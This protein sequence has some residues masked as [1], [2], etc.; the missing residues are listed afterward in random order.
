MR[1]MRAALAAGCVLTASIP[2]RAQ[3][4]GDWTTVGND[5]QRS[6]W[7]RGDG[8]IS[9]QAIAKPGFQLAW[10]VKLKGEPRQMQSVTPPAL[11]DF[12]IGHRGFRALGFFGNGSGA[13]TG[14]DTDLSRIEWERNIA[15]GTRN[16]TIPCPGGVT[17]PLSR[18]TSLGYPGSF[19]GRGGRGTP[20]K[21][22]VGEAFEGAVTIRAQTPPPAPPPPPPSARR[23]A[24]APNP[25]ARQPQYVYAIDA[26]G[27]LH[28]M[29]VS[30][31][32]EPNPAVNFLPA[33]SNAQG[34]LVSGNTA[35]AATANGCAGSTD[36]VWAIDLESKMARSWKASGHVAGIAGMAFTP[37]GLIV[38]AA[39][40]ELAVVDSANMEKKGA[41]SASEAFT[42][43]PVVFEYKGKDLA[44]ATTAGKLVVI[45]AASPGALL[46]QTDLPGAGY[47]TGALSSW[48][49]AAGV[50]WI[51]APVGGASGPKSGAIMAWR[52]VN[53]GSGMALESGWS[54]GGMVSPLPPAVVNGVVFAVSSGEN[55]DAKAS[56]AERA[57]K[58][59]PAVLYAID[60]SSGKTVWN[61]GSTIASFVR[62]GGLAAGG[63]HVYVG[64]HDG[65]QYSFAFP[66][67]Y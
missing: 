53:S 37:D 16:G 36:A 48:Q 32:D 12:F 61:S 25:F 41:Y 30:N 50:R 45:N 66:M 4:G 9:P 33:G 18:P 57:R 28:A 5:A 1:I 26:E 58:S 13:M 46:A 29:Y 34:L 22:G 20:A 14:I 21:S 55:R 54:A 11:L 43:S 44:A 31:G 56:A 6:Y 40:S 38:V 47:A 17:S 7:A 23:S 3:R 42:S 51:L 67:E 59:V 62:T 39:G 65:T 35:Y 8:K 15:G 2:A 63:G 19:A 60:G 24:P 10:K 27:K 64:A 52:L 49:D